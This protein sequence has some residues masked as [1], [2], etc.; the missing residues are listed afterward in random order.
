M[1]A[2][3]IGCQTA[4]ISQVL[5]ADLNF[6]LEQALKISLLLGLTED[7]KRYLL[8]LVEKS[9]AGTIELKAHFQK[10]LEEVRKNRPSS[11]NALRRTSK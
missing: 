3:A 10:Q 6:G 9:R 7:E 2:R 5:N 8:F 1:R 11:A 4:Y